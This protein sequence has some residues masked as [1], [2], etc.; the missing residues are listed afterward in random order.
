MAYAM[1]HPIKPVPEG[2]V[3]VDYSPLLGFVAPAVRIDPH[4]HEA[5]A[6]PETDLRKIADIIR[7]RRHA[8]LPSDKSTE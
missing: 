8:G 3:K 5:D 2:E 1:G 6:A 4:S 7:D